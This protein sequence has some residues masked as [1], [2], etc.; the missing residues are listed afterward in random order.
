MCVI[1][2]RPLRP[3]RKERPLATTTAALS[4]KGCKA[5]LRRRDHPLILAYLRRALDPSIRLFI[6]RHSC[7]TRLQPRQ[8]TPGASRRLA[9]HLQARQFLE[10]ENYYGPP[11]A[12]R[13]NPRRPDH[14]VSRKT[15]SPGSVEFLARGRRRLHG[16]L[17]RPQ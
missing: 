4:R 6:P 7:R 14:L 12:P 1:G 8:S 10:S 16:H 13:R 3:A 15:I 9:S 17:A 5:R 2:I 11:C